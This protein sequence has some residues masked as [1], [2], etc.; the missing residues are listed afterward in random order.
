V[1]P[2]SIESAVNTTRAAFAAVRS[3]ESGGPIH[4]W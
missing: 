1:S 2:V 4:V 3:L